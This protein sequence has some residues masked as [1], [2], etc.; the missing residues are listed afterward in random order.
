MFTWTPLGA[1]ETVADT[2]VRR[3]AA[4]PMRRQVTIKPEE[5]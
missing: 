5:T 3:R 2:P 1:G 4:C